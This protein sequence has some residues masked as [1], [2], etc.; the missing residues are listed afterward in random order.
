MVSSERRRPGVRRIWLCSHGRAAPLQHYG[1]RGVV[2]YQAETPPISPRVATVRREPT[3]DRQRDPL[4]PQQSA[5]S[6]EQHP[7]PLHRT[8]SQSLFLMLSANL[9]YLPHLSAKGAQAGGGYA[10]KGCATLPSLPHLAASCLSSGYSQ[11]PGVFSH[12]IRATR[13][14]ALHA[15]DASRPGCSA[16]QRKPKSQQLMSAVS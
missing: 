5:Q 4:S 7:R 6:R 12:Y 9:Y 13:P 14:K 1:N 16:T 3:S 15:P 2:S 10:R 8:L 11:W